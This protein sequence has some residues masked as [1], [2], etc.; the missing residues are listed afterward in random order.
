MA[1]AREL[2]KVLTDLK[3]LTGVTF[4]VDAEDPDA[5]DAAVRQIM[6]LTNA[7]K[8]K[9]NKANFIQNLLM[10]N[11]LHV[12]MYNRAKKLHIDIE[13]N[14]MVFIIETRKEEESL[15]LE[16]MKQLFT[17][18][19]QGYITSVDKNNIILVRHMDENE[20][21][22]DMHHVAETIVD[23]LNTEAMAKVRVAYSNPSR[24]LDT[25]SKAYKEARMALDVGRIFYMEET[26]IP[27]GRLGIGRLIYQL[28]IPLCK[29][30]LEEVF[31]DRLPDT[32][33]EETI[34]T[35][36]KFFENNLNISETA[37]QLYVHRNT[38]VYR[39]EKLQKMTGLDIRVFEDALT[40]KIATMVASYMKYMKED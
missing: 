20:T 23:M 10:D 3:N 6:Q 19:M 4:Q 12:D 34:T 15:V 11:V 36:N 14:R 27:Y 24:T 28:P 8:E 38:L 18:Q 21:L 29:M 1:G 2:E 17:P 13:A 35:I 32:F 26:I 40:F 25:L 33:D 30:Y 37:R 31:G 9:Y 5:V 7:Y 22:E 16:T 39:L